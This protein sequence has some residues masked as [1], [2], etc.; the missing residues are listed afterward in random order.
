[1]VR[2]AQVSAGLGGNGVGDQRDPNLVYASRRGGCTAALPRR[3][4]DAADRAASDVVVRS[5]AIRRRVARVVLMD[6]GT[7]Q[8][9]ATELWM[10]GPEARAVSPEDRTSVISRSR[11]SAVCRRRM[12]RCRGPRRLIDPWL[13]S[14]TQ[15]G[16]TRK[17]DLEPEHRRVIAHLLFTARRLCMRRIRF[18]VRWLDSGR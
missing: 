12:P 8:P 6:D 10:P 4:S 15:S 13:V 3:G 16:Q 17:F 9:V 7:P 1:L 2:P 5:L 14:I 11:S 18:G